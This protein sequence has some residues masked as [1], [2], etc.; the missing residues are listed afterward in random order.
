MLAPPPLIPAPAEFQYAGQQAFTFDAATSIVFGATAGSETTFAARQTQ[1]AVHDATGLSLPLRKSYD[2]E[3]S[4]PRVALLLT[5]RDHLVERGSAA[6]DESPQAY[7]LSVTRE[8]ISITATG[9]AGLFYGVQTLR[10]L[11]RTFGGR[12][13]EL[14]IRDRPALAHRGV[15]LDVSRGKV[16][17]MATLLDLVDRL[18]AYKYNQ[19]QLYVEHTFHFARHPDIGAGSEPLRAEEIMTLDDAC[20]ARHVELVPNLQ[21]FGHQRR[22]LSLPRYSYLDEVGWRW[23]LTPAREETY[24]LLDE[25]YADFLPAFTSSWLNVDCDETWDLG[26]GQSAELARKLGKGQVYVRHILHLRELAAKYG[27]RIMLWADVLHHYPDLVTSLPED[28]LLLDWEYG[29]ADGY[30]TAEALGKSG[31]RFWVC[32]GTSSWNTLFPRLDNAIGNIRNFVRDGLAAGATGMLLTDWGDYGHYQPLSL[33]WYPYVFGA[34]TAWTGARTSPEEFDAAFA[35]LFLGRPAGDNSLVAMRRLGGAVTAP[36]LGFPNRSASALALFDDPLNGDVV[37]H[38]QLSALDELEAAAAD[39]IAAWATLPDPGL[40]HDYGFIARL[41]AFAAHKVRIS[42]ELRET[43]RVLA[44]HPSPSA[45]LS[46]LDEGIAALTAVR[47]GLP[48]VRSEFETVWLRHAR[49]SEIHLILQHFDALDARYGV[50][51]GWLG[52]QRARYAA[53][54][55]LDAEVATYAPGP[56]FPLWEQGRAELRR[57]VDLVGVAAL[58]PD[59]QT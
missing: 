25:L 58:P 38:I 41:I 49:R 26:T 20:R 7:G 48:A 21:S 40:R 42:R 47:D 5:G 19:L 57:L 24:R 28:V 14:T 3:N 12:L 51:L 4:G 34:A 30:P 13:P 29:A 23:S 32:P 56:Y 39:A 17:T 46:R 16:P 27:R 11:L 50:A 37:T 53:G 31:R 22:L 43:L 54:E 18:A 52:E 8:A 33:S 15:M 6:S 45:G 44:E 36:T 59:V 55:Q 10:Q 2:T 1:A 35:P 9:E